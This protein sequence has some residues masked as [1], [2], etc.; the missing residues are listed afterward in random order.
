MSKTVREVL[1]EERAEAL[2]LAGASIATRAVVWMVDALE[3][4]FGGDT[5]YKGIYQ[6]LDALVES[7]KT[8]K[9]SLKRRQLGCENK[10]SLCIDIFNA[11]DVLCNVV[12]SLEKK[13]WWEGSVPALD[14]QGAAAIISKAE[15][16]KSSDTI[17]D[18]DTMWI[19][20]RDS[21]KFVADLLSSAPNIY[22]ETCAQAMLHHAY[23]EL[24]PEFLL[25][26]HAASKIKLYDMQIAHV[27]NYLNSVFKICDIF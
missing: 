16:L 22:T 25:A 12:S 19:F 2:G 26:A 3:R 11:I 5:N 21:V 1:L 9:R 10:L 24:K 6:A 27:L 20:L 7:A 4:A 18:V 15:Q 13:P 8:F 14:R 23:H 17:T